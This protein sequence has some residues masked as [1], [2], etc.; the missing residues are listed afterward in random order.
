MKCILCGDETFGSIGAAG[1]TWRNIC[2]PCKNSEDA[3]LAFKVRSANKGHALILSFLGLGEL[4][5]EVLAEQATDSQEH[6]T[7]PAEEKLAQFNYGKD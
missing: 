5:S 2:Q 1:L 3:A 6:E 4:G 7:I